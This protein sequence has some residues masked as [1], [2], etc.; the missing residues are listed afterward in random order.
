MLG[1]PHLSLWIEQ[2]MVGGDGLP[3]QVVLK[4]NLLLN[5]NLT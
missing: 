3:L 2:R 1:F 4:L 5:I